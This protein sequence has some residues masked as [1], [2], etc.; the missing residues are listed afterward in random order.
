M[1][2]HALIEGGIVINVIVWDSDEPVPETVVA[3]PEALRVDI[4]WGWTAA[5][6]FAQP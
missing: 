4:G 5:T 6:G 3:I 1:T 2:R